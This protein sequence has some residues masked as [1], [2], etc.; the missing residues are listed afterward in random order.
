MSRA[1]ARGGTVRHAPPLSTAD[2]MLEMAPM[3]VTRAA[4]AMDEVAR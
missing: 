4:S 2:S 1:A 3:R